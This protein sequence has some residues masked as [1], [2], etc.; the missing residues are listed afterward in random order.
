MFRL[1]HL[2]SGFFAL[3]IELFFYERVIA[4]NLFYQLKHKEIW[5][6]FIKNHYDNK[7]N[8]EYQKN[9]QHVLQ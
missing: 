5:L 8:D 3:F 1:Y 4:K 2:L 7:A 6:C 9:D